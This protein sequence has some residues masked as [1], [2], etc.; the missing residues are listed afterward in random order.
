LI[1]QRPEHRGGRLNI[2]YLM[3]ATAAVAV[4]ITVA[5]AIENL[6][7][8]ADSLLLGVRAPAGP[9]LM[10]IAVSSIY[11]L[12]VVTWLFAVRSGD[13]WQSPGKVLAM[14]FGSM[15]VLNW[16]L[17]TVAGVVMMR[18]IVDLGPVPPTGVP[19]QLCYIAGIWY[20]SFAATLGYPLFA[21]VFLFILVKTRRQPMHWRLAW[22]AFF[23]FDL[24]MI[25]A[26][27]R[28]SNTWIPLLLRPRF[29]VYA[30][31]VPMV[32]MA[33]ALLVDV[34]RRRSLDWWTIVTVVPSLILWFGVLIT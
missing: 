14:L 32:C 25:A 29:V 30:M 27:H 4:G 23:V 26:S 22:L 9:N 15:C 21:P 6:Y 34:V 3:C 28:S 12:S 5:R 19:S 16:G 17:D 11:G 20:R 33:V 31:G 10:G 24:A 7:F 8:P 2:A 13:V 1:F 18:R